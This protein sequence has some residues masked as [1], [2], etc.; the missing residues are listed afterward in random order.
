MDIR[1]VKVD[2]LTLLACLPST[3]ILLL[4]F[5]VEEH[6]ICTKHFDNVYFIKFNSKLNEK[7]V[8]N[9]GETVT[10]MGTGK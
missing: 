9:P 6:K 2:H 1:K 7:N 5:E 8:W 10:F 3:L 4:S